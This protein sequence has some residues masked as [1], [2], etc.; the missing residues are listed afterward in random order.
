MVTQI[1]IFFRCYSFLIDSQIKTGVYVKSTKSHQYLFPHVTL[2][3]VRKT[4]RL[5]NH[6]V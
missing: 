1:H 3:I 6:Y 5:V 2:N 4:F